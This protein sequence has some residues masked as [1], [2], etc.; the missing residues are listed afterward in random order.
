MMHFDLSKTLSLVTMAG[1]HAYGMSTPESD[2]DIL[3]VTTDK[4][5]VNTVVMKNS[6]RERLQ[7]IVV[8]QNDFIKMKIENAVFYKEVN[9]GKVL[10]IKE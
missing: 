5:K 2:I 4:S 1:S 8:T 10:W 3:F 9:E 7:P 6:L